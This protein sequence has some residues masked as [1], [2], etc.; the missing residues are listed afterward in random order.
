[1]AIEHVRA[2]LMRADWTVMASDLDIELHI[3]E[4]TAD[5]PG[6]WSAFFDG[7][8]GVTSAYQEPLCM[9][10]LADGRRGPVRIV[11]LR[12]TPAGNSYEF[13]GIGP[14]TGTP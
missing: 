2:A 5:Q 11:G 4:P 6:E 14:L 9:L 12:M 13:K 3:V 10:V 1:M 7:P 8:R